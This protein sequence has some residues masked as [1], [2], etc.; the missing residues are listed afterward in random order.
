MRKQYLELSIMLLDVRIQSDA[1]VGSVL[2]EHVV[3]T[4]TIPVEDFEEGFAEDDS[5]IVEF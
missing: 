4:P 3:T 5:F 1:L 2:P